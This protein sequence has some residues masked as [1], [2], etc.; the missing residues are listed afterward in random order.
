MTY[1]KKGEISE[2]Q[3][4]RIKI[5]LILYFVVFRHKQI[6]FCSKKSLAKVLRL[7]ISDFLIIL[8]KSDDLNDMDWKNIKLVIFDVDG[9]LYDQTKLRNK[10][11]LALI[12]YYLLRPWRLRE[13]LIIY[14]FRK[15]REKRAGFQACDLQKEQYIWC[16]EK[17]NF[18]IDKIKLVVDKWIFNFPNQY[19]KACKYP[20]ITF[21]FD[22][23]IAKGI[24]I[25]IYSDY[26][27]KLK[28][29]CMGLESRL[30]VS[31]TDININS[32]KPLP[33]GLTYILNEFNIINTNEC[34]YIGDRDEL[35][36]ECA[37]Q[38]G[39][40]Y[41]IIDKKLVRNNFYE[42]LSNKLL[43]KN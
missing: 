33:K 19:L 25:A 27:S 38:A 1:C 30:L 13:L 40:P 28:M 34:L 16:A 15:E 31:S 17:V 41:L 36:G 14:H 4:P 39:I 35:D 6:G 26:D 2:Y 29:E 12:G 42:I 43:C 10:M 23:L 37:R 3:N 11:V 9:T 22:A 20:G 8:R 7:T 5:K 18:P 32:M 24:S 21:F